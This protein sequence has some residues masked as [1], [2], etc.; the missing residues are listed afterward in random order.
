MAGLWLEVVYSCLEF[1]FF[2]CCWYF[3]DSSFGV[4]EFLN[5]LFFPL[6][7]PSRAVVSNNTRLA[8]IKHSTLH[9][10]VWP[11][12]WLCFNNKK[13]Q[14][15]W[16]GL[17]L[18]RPCPQVFLWKII[19]NRLL[20]EAPTVY[21]SVSFFFFS[22]NVDRASPDPWGPSLCMHKQRKYFLFFLFFTF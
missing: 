11:G 19:L 12:L 2:F 18:E 13:P 17:F 1:H 20:F 10:A 15:L 5:A 9:C 7:V 14:L 22:L 3:S 8:I 16:W 21:A 4:S 6:L